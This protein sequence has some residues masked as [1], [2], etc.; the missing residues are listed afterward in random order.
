MPSL[1]TYCSTIIQFLQKDP[2]GIEQEKQAKQSIQLRKSLQT[3]KDEELIF[4]SKVSVNHLKRRSEQE[5]STETWTSRKPKFKGQFTV[6]KDQPEP[7]CPTPILTESLG[8]PPEVYTAGQ[9]K[10][11]FQACED[12][13]EDEDEDDSA[14]GGEENDVLLPD[15][16]DQTFRFSAV[17]DGINVATGFQSLFTEI[18]KKSVY[19]HDIDQAL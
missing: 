11:P 16:T 3:E 8:S 10:N 2:H 1:S 7:P 19:I 17:L 6:D 4:K 15:N 5:S 13:E 9:E 18:K 12:D 14:A